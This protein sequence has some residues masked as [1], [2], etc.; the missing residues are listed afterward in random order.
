MAIDSNKMM[1]AIYDALYGSL[2]GDVPGVAASRSVPPGSGFLTLLKPGLRIEPMVYANAWS[3]VNPE[4]SDTAG[5]ALAELVSQAPSLNPMFTP[6]GRVE[7][8]YEE[9]VRAAVDPSPPNPEQ[10]AA[11]AAAENFLFDDGVDFDPVTGQPVTVPNSVDSPAYANYKNKFALF[12]AALTSYLAQWQQVDQTNPKDMQAWAVISPILQTKVRMAYA[13]FD[14][15]KPGIIKDKESILG[16]AS[17]T[18]LVRRFAEA[19]RVFELAP[20]GEGFSSYLPVQVFP[21]N[22][23]TTQAYSSVDLTSNEIHTSSSS[24]FGSWNAGGGLDFGLFSIGGSGGR[25]WSNY[26]LHQ[27]T[28]NL[29][30]SFQFA[31]VDIRRAWLKENL[32]TTTGWSVEGRA[33][34]SYSNGNV[35]PSNTG[36]FPLL[37]VAFIVAR[38][39][40]ATANWS[41]VDRQTFSQT[42]QGGGGIRIGPFHFGGG[43]SSSSTTSSTWAASNQTDLYTPDVELIA[44]LNRVVP[45]CPPK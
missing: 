4:G 17:Q 13:E 16:Q 41:A 28:T 33:K 38:Q 19:R 2:T 22:W 7:D 35:D 9:I 15:S 26:T 36:V 23:A 44:F 45:A 11:V 1:Q 40:R 32:L 27:D 12:E 6:I 21:A 18:S 37:P 39:V 14:T 29:R 10:E 20:R 31:R 3:P 30:L 42:L 34:N 25:S 43:A 24:S 5:R 8:F